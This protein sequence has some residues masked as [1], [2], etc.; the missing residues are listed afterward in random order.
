[1]QAQGIAEG[2]GAGAGA[3][4]CG[5]IQETQWFQVAPVG[6]ETECQREGQSQPDRGAMEREFGFYTIAITEL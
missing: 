4:N 2:E 6:K 5:L 3:G 1:M